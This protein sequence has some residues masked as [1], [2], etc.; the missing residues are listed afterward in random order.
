VISYVFLGITLGF[1]AAVQPGPYQ[2]FL[3]SRTLQHGW[4]NTL[5]AVFVPPLSDIPAIALA[6]LLL[7]SL[8]DWMEN[9]LYFV[10]GFFVLFLAYG[11]FKSFRN[12]TFNQAALLGSKRQSFFKALTLNLLNPNPYLYWSL[13]SGPL[14]L[15]G[16]REEPANGAGQWSQASTPR[17]SS[18]APGLS[19][20]LQAWAGSS[21]R[22][23]RILLGI[24]VVA[25]ALF[26]CYQ[27]WLGVRSVW[28]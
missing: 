27:L 13:V 26:G 6:L 12:Y 8:P 10:G 19:S 16:W 9:A 7:T 3:I 2:T 22:S 1:A 21:P 25:L 11:A 24:S 18:P 5:P 14:L 20:C 4:R 23:N 17:C 15:R 28:S